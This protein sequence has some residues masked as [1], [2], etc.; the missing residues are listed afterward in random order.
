MANILIDRS[1]YIKLCDFGIAKKLD[2]GETLKEQTGSRV[3]WAPEVIK[4]ESYR[5]MPDWWSVGIIIYQLM[6]RQTPF[7]FEKSSG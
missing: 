3:T 6:C 2:K 1:G 4:Q 7:H 5:F